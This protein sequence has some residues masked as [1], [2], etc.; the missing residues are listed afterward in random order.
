LCFIFFS[1]TSTS[2]LLKDQIKPLLE[3]YKNDPISL[4]WVDKYEEQSLHGQF[5]NSQYH[6]VAYKPKQGRFAGYPLADFSTDSLRGWIDN[7]LGG[8][9]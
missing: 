4:V 2:A 1:T 5:A 3:A 9:G 7:V 8:G 6:L